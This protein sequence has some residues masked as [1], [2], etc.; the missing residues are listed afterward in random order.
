MNRNANIAGVAVRSAEELLCCGVFIFMM[1][2]RLEAMNSCKQKL[3][4][5]SLCVIMSDG[6]LVLCLPQRLVNV[7]FTPHRTGR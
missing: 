4:R 5:V 6:Y 1:P 3:I 2:L 7:L